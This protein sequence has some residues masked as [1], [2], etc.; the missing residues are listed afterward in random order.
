MYAGIGNRN[1]RYSKGSHSFGEEF[2]IL[3]HRRPAGG[4]YILIRTWEDVSFVGHVAVAIGSPIK[5]FGWFSNLTARLASSFW[6]KFPW[7]QK[8]S[9]GPTHTESRAWIIDSSSC[10]KT[11]HMLTH[12]WSILRIYLESWV[13]IKQTRSWKNRASILPWP[14]GIWYYYY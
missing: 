2:E 13:Y 9:F 12:K 3:E 1:L 11:E 4:S 14:S 10:D 8:R 7:H 5:G 6:M